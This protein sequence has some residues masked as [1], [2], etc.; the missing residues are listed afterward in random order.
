MSTKKDPKAADKDAGKEERPKAAGEDAGKEKKSASHLPK[1]D[2]NY[3]ATPYDDVWR[4]IA[5]TL[6]RR[7]L[8]LLNRIF[9]T[10]FTGDEQ[11]QPGE[12][13]LMVLHLS[14]SRVRRGVDSYFTVI[15]HA[16]NRYAFHIE[17]QTNPDGSIVL[18]FA[19]Y[20]LQLA[21][22]EGTTD[23][24]GILHLHMPKSALINLRGSGKSEPLEIHFH[25]DGQVLVH[26]IE[27]RSMRSFTVDSL[28]QPDGL[29]LLPFYIFTHTEDFKNLANDK[30]T[31]HRLLAEFEDI[32][33]R[34]EQLDAS[35]EIDLME[36]GNL[37]ELMR[38]VLRNAVPEKLISEEDLDMAQGH[39]LKL[40]T[41]K[42]WDDG[43]ER[44]LERGR[45]EGLEQGERNSI[46][47]LVHKRLIDKAVGA[48]E[49]GL[50]EAEFREAY[51][52]TYPD[53]DSE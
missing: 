32:C 40:A 43:L 48:A 53:A 8:L 10:S 18:R 16:G 23:E 45:K 24:N 1:D 19:E 49:L 52:A 36:H 29:A 38:K 50:T 37:L 34:L 11:I 42:A 12:T 39:V 5:Q 17:C 6:Q 7:L 28:L 3:S 13:E 9:G 33:R 30:E 41:D 4:T 14:G 31:A 44:G 21:L 47:R 2:P 15:D 51:R 46:L 27:T 22:N 20:D 35:G 25:E 26:K